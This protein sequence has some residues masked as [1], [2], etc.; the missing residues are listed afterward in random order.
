MCAQA[1][2]VEPGG[3]LRDLEDDAVSEKTPRLRP[4]ERHAGVN[5]YIAEYAGKLGAGSIVAR[6]TD[7]RAIRLADPVEHGYRTDP[8]PTRAEGAAPGDSDWHIS[9]TDG[10]AIPGDHDVPDLS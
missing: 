3:V 6:T 1:E 7:G 2:V 9:L 10:V 5:P 4:H 8:E